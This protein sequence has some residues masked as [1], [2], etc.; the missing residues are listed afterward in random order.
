[1]RARD[2]ILRAMLIG[3]LV[4]T[5]LALVIY[6][7]YR[8]EIAAGASPAAAGLGAGVVAWFASPLRA[9]HAKWAGNPHSKA[10]S[11]PGVTHQQHGAHPSLRRDRQ[12]GTP[13]RRRRRRARPAVRVACHLTSPSS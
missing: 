9:A 1:M 5:A 2:H 4:G 8:S 11:L 10:V 6:G 3:A 13:C 12:L 7:E